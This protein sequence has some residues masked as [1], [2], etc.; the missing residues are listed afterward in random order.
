MATKKLSA[1]EAAL[2]RASQS[3]QGLQDRVGQALKNVLNGRDAQ[4]NACAG[5][6][7]TGCGYECNGSCCNACVGK[8]QVWSWV[9]DVFDKTVV[10]SVSGQL[11][12][13]SYTDAAGTISFGD[14][15]PMEV[16][17]T[18]MGEASRSMCS[19]VTSLKEAGAAYN[20]KTGE[21]TVTIIRPGLNTSKSK[22]Y[23]AGVLKRD[24]GIFENAKMFL[25]HAT[26]AEDKAR[27]EGDVRQWVAQVGKPW[28]EADGRIRA[29]AQ[30]IDPPFKEKLATLSEAGLLQEMGVSIRAIGYGSE[31]EV[32][33]S[34]GTKV[35]TT[36][37]ERLLASRSV[38]FVTY[39][40]AGGQC[41]VLESHN[42]DEFDLDL[43]TI[44]Q[45]RE[46]R[47]DLIDL[48]ESNA[49]EAVSMTKTLE[50]QLQEANATAAAEKL[51]AD[52]ATAALN[53]ATTKAAKADAAKHLATLCET[54]KLPEAA[55]TRLAEQ[56][57]E[58]DKTEGMQAAVES[59][60]SFIK[61]VAP[62]AATTTPSKEAA[63]V[64][65][66][67]SD[68][69]LEE[70]TEKPVKTED[71]EKAFRNLGLNESEAKIAAKF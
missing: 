56:F 7:C 61:S 68:V 69:N 31:A 34:A 32:E 57:K 30:V 52:A 11:Y 39:P 49:R 29:K 51:R 9:R 58:A 19:S 41:E 28:A 46:R 10:Y 33:E 45:L 55:R 5:D 35:K 53:E 3:L 2:L 21:L 12:Q 26:A 17:Y 24:M 18:P 44:E 62:G 71:I 40:G 43:A 23:P 13:R 15:V 67:G 20:K 47:P 4:T 50:Q 63:K 60:V 59:M 42:P 66:M 14:E 6:C 70:G 27:P 8:D 25:N 48:L 38:D 54:A 36:M 16:A 37:V 22:Y 1:K 64:I 65:G